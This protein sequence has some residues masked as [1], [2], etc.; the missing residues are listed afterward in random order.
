[1][2]NEHV[3]SVVRSPPCP[4]F[5]YRLAHLFFVWRR[6]V[7]Q[8]STSGTS[9]TCP[10]LYGRTTYHIP[11]THL[12]AQSAA[13]AAV[14]AAAAAAAA[15]AVSHR[16]PDGKNSCW[17]IEPDSIQTFLSLLSYA[18]FLMYAPS[19]STVVEFAASICLHYILC[20][21]GHARQGGRQPAVANPPL[22]FIEIRLIKLCIACVR[23][24]VKQQ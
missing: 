14:A 24:K 1:M 7:S 15:A 12:Y 13:A 16:V 4:L 6:V 8:P 22:Q 3:K 9:D 5:F 11:G 23:V 21:Y 19:G 2:I 17:F 18:I 20:N 10:V